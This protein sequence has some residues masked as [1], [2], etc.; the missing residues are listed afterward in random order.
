MSANFKN[1]LPDTHDA[2]LRFFQI[3]CLATTRFCRGFASFIFGFSGLLVV[4]S[5]FRW[6]LE[7]GGLAKLTHASWRRKSSYFFCTLYLQGFL[8]FLSF[9]HLRQLH[10]LGGKIL[11]SH[12]TMNSKTILSVRFR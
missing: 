1:G 12:I 5:A 11:K 10:Y 9:G 4:I 3:P 7:T 2:C 6:F 8:G